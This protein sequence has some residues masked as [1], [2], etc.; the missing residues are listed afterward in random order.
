MP[1][2]DRISILGISSVD[3]VA[4]LTALRAVR[5]WSGRRWLK[6]GEQVLML[7]FGLL[8]F[9][10][11]L[12]LGYEANLGLQPWGLFQNG[13][14]RFI[15]LTYGQITIAVGAVMVGVSWLARVPPGFGTICNM[16]L[17]G[18]WLDL[19]IA[20]LPPARGL[21]DGFVVLL[22]GLVTL[23]FASA[24]YIKAGLGA[25]PRDSF[26]IAILRWTGWR[27]GVARVAMDG[28]VFA[29]GALLD[30]HHVGLGT[31]IY[32]FGF[33]LAMNWTFRLLGVSARGTSRQGAGEGER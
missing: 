13:L 15:P 31:V 22:V 23:A 14:T 9:G 21:I 12:A 26:M 2:T 28:T 25:G 10:L 19:F 5:A 32:T 29:L 27:V 11:G 8:I 17:V 7:Q 4:P 30:P 16:V 20:I 18:L 3:G 33:G 6:L 1:N 24:L